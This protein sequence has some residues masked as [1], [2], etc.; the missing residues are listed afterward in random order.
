MWPETVI[1]AF[2]LQ[3]PALLGSLQALAGQTQSWIAAGTVDRA[4][5]H[6]Y[7][8]SVIALSPR[9]TLVGVYHK[10]ILVPFAEYLP[11]NANLRRLPLFNRASEFLAGEGP[12]ILN[13]DSIKAGMLVCYESAFA[14]Y[15]RR[16]INAGADTLIIVTDDAWFGHTAGPY[17]HFDMSIMDAVETGRWVVRGADT[18]VSAIID[19][20]GRVVAA[21]PLDEA[22]LVVADIGQPIEAPYVR[23]GSWWLLSLALIALAVGLVPRHENGGGWR[24]RRGRS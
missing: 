15:A 11:F 8:N 3:Q 17:Q 4:G 9:G 10:H 16:T 13:L 19:P 20:K 2:P 18:G 7:Y 6:A 14:E 12:T 21:L 24:S 22:G 5:A 23:W 1:T